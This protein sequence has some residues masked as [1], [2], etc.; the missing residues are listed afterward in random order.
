V[1]SVAV[2]DG[3]MGRAIGATGVRGSAAKSRRGRC[4]LSLLSLGLI[5]VATP[6]AADV[7]FSAIFSKKGQSVYSP[8]PAVDINTG[9]RRLGPAPFDFGGTYGGFVDPCLVVSC[10]TGAQA[11]AQVSGNLGLNYGVKFNSGS[12]DVLYPVNVGIQTPG[13][14]VVNEAFALGSSYNISGYSGGLSTSLGGQTVVAKLQTHSPTLE[15]FVDLDA[16]FHAF[17]G[18]EGCV[19][20]ICK[21]PALGPFDANESRNLLA[22][23]RNGDGLIRLGDE[24]VTLKQNVSALDGNLTGRLNIPNIDA[25]STPSGGSTAGNLITNGRD[26]LA[27]LDANIGNIVAKALGIPLTGKIA[28]IGYNLLSVN[29]GLA[30]DLR[31]SISLALTPMLTYDFLS[32]VRQLLSNGLWGAPTQHITIALGDDL[33]LRSNARSLGVLP[34][35]SLMATLSNV[36][37]LVVQGDFSLQALAANV[38]GLNIGPLYDSGN[39]NGGLFSIPLFQDSFNIA[40]GSVTGTPFNITQGS[41]PFFSGDPGYRAQFRVIGDDP[42]NPA[43]DAGEI[44]ALD[45]DPLHCLSF[46]CFPAHFADA[47]P[48]TLD[49]HGQRAFLL[50]SDSLTLPGHT[51]GPNSTDADQLALLHG[52]GFTEDRP[53]LL[54]PPGD[55]LGIP[56]PSAWALMLTGFGAMGAALRRRRS[57]P[58]GELRAR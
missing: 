35:T 44:V 21:G 12:A 11:G 16:Q 3:V 58:S 14:S 24:V 39:V 28:G 57:R 8:G 9:T 36:T 53:A 22:I 1:L 18:A 33:T 45:L 37:D 46:A 51:S 5:A 49:D 10:R 20:G 25:A 50:A 54:A 17:V 56:E 19:F 15:A 32:P 30:L 52:V 29:A 34:T 27:A 2:E 42:S 6:A 26:N 48:S 40:F 55:P 47:S 31:Q 41:S 4:A 7:G 13:V 23:N 43:L 38:Y